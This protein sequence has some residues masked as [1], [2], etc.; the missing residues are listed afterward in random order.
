MPGT[1]KWQA[2]IC[3]LI[4]LMP[5]KQL[6]A[7]LGAASL[8]GPGLGL[9]VDYL[10]ASRYIRP[11]DSVKTTST[12]AQQRYNFGASFLLGQHIDTATKKVRTWT[13]NAGGSY[14]K[15]TNKDYDAAHQVFPDELLDAQVT[16]LHYRSLRNP[17]W[18]LAGIVSVGLFT[19]MKQVDQQD[20]F[21]TGGLLFIKQ[22]SRR[23]SYGLGAVL[24]NTFGTPMILPAFMV[25]WQ[26]D[27]KFRIDINFPEKL[28]ITTALSS[29]TDL[30]L[31][32]RMR[33]ASY[34][35]EKHPG[36]Q[37][38]MG[39]AELSAGLENTW[40]LNKH[41]DFVVAGGSILFNDITF[42]ERKL[43]EM[44]AEKP[45]HRLATNLFVSTGFRWKF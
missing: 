21:V 34:D 5:A 15:L 6:W 39:Y 13:L 35:V 2:A 23:F 27:N 8:N 29:Y 30:G 44:F 41:F 4:T 16:L 38:L 45:R 20:I 26:T 7:Q 14:T 3:L 22:H 10:P 36:N 25:R 32:L 24:S 1:K 18:G 11:E 17:K 43:S 40:H 12:T 19:D 37:R 9:S 28:S 33:G 42:K 31:A